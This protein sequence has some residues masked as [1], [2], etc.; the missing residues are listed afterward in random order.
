MYFTKSLILALAMLTGA[1]ALPYS[2][3]TENYSYRANNGNLNLAIDGSQLQNN[4]HAAQHDPLAPRKTWEE[5]VHMYDWRDWVFPPQ[6]REKW[7]PE[8]RRDFNLV[9]MPHLP[10]NIELPSPL[11]PTHD[12]NLKEI[13]KIAV[14]QAILEER[15]SPSQ[16][17]LEFAKR[18]RDVISFM[19]ASRCEYMENC[20]IYDEEYEAEKQNV[21]A[22]RAKLALLA[23]FGPTVPYSAYL[24]WE[25]VNIPAYKPPRYSKERIYDPLRNS[26]EKRTGLEGLVNLGKQL[27][28][29][30][31]PQVH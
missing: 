1:T 23:L 15:K 13:Y 3:T 21:A 20:G 18:K 6:I 19:V 29:L 8:I 17:R 26:T 9:A 22:K 25:D 7:K 5:A 14:A 30:G 10:G 4:P 16:I 28:A 27:K 24:L 12:K 11:L 31:F 2:N